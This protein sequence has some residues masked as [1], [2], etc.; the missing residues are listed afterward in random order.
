MINKITIFAPRKKKIGLWNKTGKILFLGLDNAGKTTLLK[1]LKSEK[2]G[3]YE[4]TEYPNVE[5]IVIGS[6]TIT[7]IDMGGHVVARRVWQ[8]YFT[9]DVTGIVFIV[10]AANSSRFEEA[11]A[12][13]NDVLKSDEVANLPVL[14]LGNKIDKNTAVQEEVLKAALGI[15]NQTTGKGKIEH[16]NVRP[17]EVF[18]CSI[19]KGEGYGAG[20]QWLTQY[21]E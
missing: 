15:S 10:D 8:K 21:L 5:E 9:D 11:R 13:L 17:L 4:P 18:M 7:T 6:L 12:E 19:V 16:K 14:I 2:L 3:Q 1:M 20:I